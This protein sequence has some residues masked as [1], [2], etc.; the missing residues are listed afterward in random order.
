LVQ[1]RH[2]WN[3]CFLDSSRTSE[4]SSSH[5]RLG[6]VRG[7]QN[8]PQ[9]PLSHKVRSRGS[10]SSPDRGGQELFVMPEPR[11]A[12]L[13]LFKLRATPRSRKATELR[14]RPSCRH[15]LEVLQGLRN[16]PQTW[17]LTQRNPWS[18]RRSLAV[19]KSRPAE[20]RLSEGF[21]QE[22]PRKARYAIS[23]RPTGS[24]SPSS[25]RR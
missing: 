1:T 3:G 13:S 11:G 2:S 9:G 20:W 22:P 12:G 10:R 21:F 4:T 23:P 25:M 15:G 14:Q 16:S 24:S 18:S 6:R 5:S 7:I 17:R 8:H 19:P